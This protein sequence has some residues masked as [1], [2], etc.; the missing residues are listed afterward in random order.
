M[1]T[2]DKEKSSEH[3]EFNPVVRYYAK[4]LEGRK[5]KPPSKDMYKKPKKVTKRYIPLALKLASRY[6]IGRASSSYCED[7]QQ[8]ALL[9]LFIAAK[10]YDPSR[11]VSFQALAT[12]V[13]MNA[14]NNMNKHVVKSS[15]EIPEDIREVE[16]MIEKSRFYLETGISDMLLEESFVRATQK[17]TKTERKVLRL[18]ATKKYGLSDI[19]RKCHMSPRRV[20][21]TIG[22]VRAQFDLEGIFD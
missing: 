19:A 15:A 3:V 2:K 7:A 8:E 12:R 1:A 20:S 11:G 16:K 10:V 6:S 21:R 18:R 9:A 14:L 4:N 22:N 13:I 5:F 17:L